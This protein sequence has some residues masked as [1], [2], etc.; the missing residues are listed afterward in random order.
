MDL[1]RI[2]L[3]LFLFSLVG[4]AHELTKSGQQVRVVSDAERNDCTHIGMVTGSNSMG[5]NVAHDVEGATNQAKNKVAELGGNGLKILN[6]DTTYEFTSVTGE[7]LKCQ[8][9]Y[10]K[11]SPNGQKSVHSH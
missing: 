1:M 6:I 2:V 8:F 11:M 10:L 5:N 4:C 9:E 7:A 3:L